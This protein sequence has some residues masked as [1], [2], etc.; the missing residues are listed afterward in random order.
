MRRPYGM[1]RDGAWRV[2]KDAAQWSFGRLL[3][4]WHWGIDVFQ[5]ETSH[6]H[7]GSLRPEERRRVRS[8]MVMAMSSLPA[9]PSFLRGFMVKVRR[10]LSVKSPYAAHPLIA[11]CAQCTVGHAPC[12]IDPRSIRNYDAVN[13]NVRRPVIHVHVSGLGEC[14]AQSGPFGVV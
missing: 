12:R 5:G 1:L 14:A 8:D 13:P 7:A 3:V 11:Y 9:C 6:A 2:L 4:A 10:R